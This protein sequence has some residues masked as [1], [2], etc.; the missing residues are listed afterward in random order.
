MLYADVVTLDPIISKILLNQHKCI[1]ICPDLRLLN[2][3]IRPTNIIKS[4]ISHA[5]VN[6]LATNHDSVSPRLIGWKNAHFSVL[7]SHVGWLFIQ[8]NQCFF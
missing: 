1:Q 3:N 6:F 5:Y 2:L 7:I 4:Y 8:T